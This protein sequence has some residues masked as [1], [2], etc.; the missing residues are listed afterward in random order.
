[1]FLYT[2]YF[3]L[4]LVAQ[5]QVSYIDN[6]NR[7]TNNKRSLRYQRGNQKPKIKKDRQHNDQM[8]KDKRTNKDLQNIT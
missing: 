6:D 8:K 7:Y 4:V 1:M 2:I 3:S 5:S